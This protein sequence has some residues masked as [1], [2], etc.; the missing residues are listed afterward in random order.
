M[1]CKVKKIKNFTHDLTNRIEK[2]N[3]NKVV[4]TKNIQPLKLTLYY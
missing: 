3:Q 1:Y 2:H 4:L